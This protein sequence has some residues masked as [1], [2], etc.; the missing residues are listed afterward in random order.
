MPNPS[1]IRT[2]AKRF[3]E[4]ASVKNRKVN[5]LRHV[6]TEETLLEIGEILEHTTQKNFK[7]FITENWSICIVCTKSIKIT[8]ITYRPTVGQKR[9][10][11]PSISL[12]TSKG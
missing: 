4:T 8:E 6:L 2:Q 3:K 9:I 12:I 11:T 7:T 1:T 10:C 5:R